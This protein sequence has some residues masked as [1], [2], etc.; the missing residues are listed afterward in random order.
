MGDRRGTCA[1]GR[2]RAR[3]LVHATARVQAPCASFRA[4]AGRGQGHDGERCR[5]GTDHLGATRRGRAGS[6]A[7]AALRRTRAGSPLG[8]HAEA[9]VPRPS[10]R[11]T[12]PRFCSTSKQFSCARRRHSREQLK[13]AAGFART[14]SL[15]RLSVGRAALSFVE[16]L[17]DSRV[18]EPIVYRPI[19]YVSSPH[20]ESTG[21]RCRRSPTR[22]ARRRSRSRARTVDASRI[23]TGSPTSGSSPTSTRVVGWDSTVPTFL[24]NE[25]HGTFAT[26]SP[27]RPNP[28]GL[29]LARIVS[30]ASNRV[31]VEGLDLLDGTPVLDLKPYVPLFDTASDDVRIGWFELH[32]D[33][34]FTR[35]SDDRFALRSRRRDWLHPASR[36]GAR[37][38]ATRRSARRRS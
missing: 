2:H 16:G 9:P 26:R 3:L 34:V 14:L 37:R 35:T 11:S 17:L 21:C 32:A 29:S 13:S 33:G 36:L 12:P 10:R 30:V 19:G 15:W 20:T 28:V 1:G 24:D 27:R 23:S 18:V 31:V 7:G 22:A 38:R 8:A 25:Q 4:R 5:P 6:T